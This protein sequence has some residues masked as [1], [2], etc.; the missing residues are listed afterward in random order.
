[1]GAALPKRLAIPAALLT[2]LCAALPAAAGKTGPL[3]YDVAVEVGYEDPPGPESLR[4]ELELEI[5]KTLEGAGCYRSVN[6]YS[7]EREQ[8]ELLLTVTISDLLDEQDFE[9][10]LARRESPRSPAGESTRMTA[11]LEVDVRLQLS[12]LPAMI[13]VR[14]KR[15]HKEYG[16]R[17]YADEDPRYEVRL[18]LIDDLARAARA[19]VCKSRKVRKEIA[20]ARAGKPL[21]D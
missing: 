20:R 18:I 6:R 11:R 21:E 4:E 8:A 7:R 2:V 9:I 19:F 16:Y 15:F 1:M 17:P 3:T 10:S 13:P 5:I 14:T 12:L